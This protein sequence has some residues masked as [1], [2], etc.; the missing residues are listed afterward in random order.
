MA[1]PE[2]PD[3]IWVRWP[4]GLARVRLVERHEPAPDRVQVRV[5]E[6]RKIVVERQL[7]SWFDDV[8]KRFPVR[9][10]DRGLEAIP[11][12]APPEE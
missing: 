9:I 2:Q 12:P 10:L 4:G 1:T 3:Q 7:A 8:R 6:L 5:D 11:L